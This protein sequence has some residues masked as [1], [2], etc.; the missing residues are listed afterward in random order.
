V[1]EEVS[2]RITSTGAT[3]DATGAW[4]TVGLL[5]LFML[6]N[7]ADR[8]VLGLAVVPIMQELGLSYAEFGLIGASFFTFFSLG[9]VVVGFLVNHIS[10][11]WVL[12]AL[13][14]SFPGRRSKCPRPRRWKAG[15]LP[16][17]QCRMPSPLARPR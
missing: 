4:I 17:P 6:I 7:F 5:I 3:A 14:M 2:T 11:K 8:A 9:A 16:W 1:E 10:T 15:R 13:A 12:A